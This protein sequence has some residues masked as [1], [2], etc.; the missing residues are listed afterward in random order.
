F[1]NNFAFDRRIVDRLTG[2]SNLTP[3]QCV[4]KLRQAFCCKIPKWIFRELDTQ[5]IFDLLVYKISGCG[6]MQGVDNTLTGLQVRQFVR[7]IDER[8]KI[9]EVFYCCNG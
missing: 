4:A 7:E 5:H 8:V 6:N 3:C 1:A 9:P 2:T